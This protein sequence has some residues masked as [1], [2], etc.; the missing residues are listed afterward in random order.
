VA[1]GVHFAAEGLE[2]NDIVDELR[3]TGV[4]RAFELYD[5]PAES[6]AMVED[7]VL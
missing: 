7:G 5:E 4:L 2:P 6:A 1:A 3:D